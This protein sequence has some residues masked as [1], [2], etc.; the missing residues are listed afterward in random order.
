MAEDPEAQRLVR[1][2]ANAAEAV[3]AIGKALMEQSEEDRLRRREYARQNSW[4]VRSEHL[5][6]LIQE[7]I[8]N[9][10]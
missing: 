7:K 5:F 1:F 3:D 9:P 6:G 8:A 2:V 4:Q 10:S